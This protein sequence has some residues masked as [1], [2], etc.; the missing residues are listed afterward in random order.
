MKGPERDDLSEAEEKEESFLRKQAWDYFNT[1]AGQR[2]TIFNFYIGLSSVT[3]TGYFASFKADSNLESV[4]VLLAGLLCFFAFVFWKLDQRTKVL[5]KNAENALK[6]FEEL[7]P[8][9]VRAKVFM[10][11]ETK[12]DAH[13][14][15]IKGWAKLMIWRWPLSY[16]DCF[17]LVYIVFFMI[18]IG[19]LMWNHLHWIQWFWRGICRLL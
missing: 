18:G 14:D 15:S 17:N 7:Q 11:E 9:H 4:R 6:Y 3:A 5:I 12:T 19:A 1:H 10:H 8:H 13:R 16:S 2:L